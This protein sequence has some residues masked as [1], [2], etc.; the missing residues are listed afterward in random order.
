M[1]SNAEGFAPDARAFRAIASLVL[2]TACGPVGVDAQRPAKA[3]VTA[4][5]PAPAPTQ[6]VPAPTLS[7]SEDVCGAAARQNW[8]G[9]SIS[10]LPRAPSGAVWRQTCTTCFKTDDF[11]PERL[12]IAFDAASGRIVSVTCG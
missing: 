6:V 10:S 3:P 12:N 8:V 5:A 1:T 4:P 7:T 9:Q 11:R 2:V